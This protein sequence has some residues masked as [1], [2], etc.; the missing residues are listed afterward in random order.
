[1]RPRDR[2]ADAATP[3]LPPRG[4]GPRAPHRPERRQIGVNLDCNGIYA[5]QPHLD[6]PAQPRLPLDAGSRLDQR[7]LTADGYPLANASTYF[8]MANYPAGNYEF[9][10]TGSGDRLVL[11]RRPARRPRHRLRR[12]DHRHRR[13]QPSWRP[14]RRYLEH[15]GDRT[16]TTSN[17]MDNF[18]L[19]MPG[20]GNGTTPEPMFTPAFLQS[21]EPFSDIRFMNWEETNDSTLANWQDRVQPNAFLT[22]GTA[23]SPTR[24]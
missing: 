20:Y 12:G 13:G 10:Y 15:A 21:L 1:M 22:D 7:P 8:A 19:M 3:R 6:R 5:D 4:R 23:A 9:S 17:P 24:T 2:T 11:R 16:S 14:T 18:H